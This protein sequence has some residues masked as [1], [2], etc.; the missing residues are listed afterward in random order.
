[1]TLGERIFAS[2]KFSP[3]ENFRCDEKNEGNGLRRL[4]FSREKVS[5]TRRSLV[6]EPRVTKA[7]AEYTGYLDWHNFHQ[8][9]SH[10]KRAKPTRANRPLGC[11]L[12][13]HLKRNI[14]GGSI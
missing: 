12:A 6:S 5:K 9:L 14:V 3:R 2:V 10:E 7:G 8:L 11:P 4:T 1:M 13:T